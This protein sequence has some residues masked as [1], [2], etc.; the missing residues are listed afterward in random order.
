MADIGEIRGTVED[1]TKIIQTV[2]G[3]ANSVLP[4]GFAIDLGINAVIAFMKQQ[5][6]AEEEAKQKFL[7]VVDS[8]EEV[9]RPT[10]PSS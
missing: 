8:L 2:L 7:E 3:L 1:V 9:K 6:L 4:G 5:G 10:P